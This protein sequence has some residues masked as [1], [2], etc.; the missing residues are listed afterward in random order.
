M[1]VLTEQIKVQALTYVF[2][3]N[4]LITKCLEIFLQHL[5]LERVDFSIAIPIKYGED[6]HQTDQEYI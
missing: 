1:H 4:G 5:D 3:S 6:L 2:Q